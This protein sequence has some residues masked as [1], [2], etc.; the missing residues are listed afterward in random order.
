[1][2]CRHQEHTCESRLNAGANTAPQ[3]SPLGLDTTWRPLYRHTE[4]DTHHGV[5]GK[6]QL[7]DTAATLPRFISNSLQHR[8]C[9]YD[10]ARHYPGFAQGG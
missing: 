2:E 10:A 6:Q 5:V 8:S 9:A 4:T 7:F 3:A 1:M